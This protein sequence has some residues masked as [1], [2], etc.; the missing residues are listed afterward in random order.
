MGGRL[1]VFWAHW[2]KIDPG[3]WVLDVVKRGYEIEFSS[4]PPQYGLFATTPVPEIP[5]KRAA[6]E[7]EI[8]SLLKKGAITRVTTANADGPLFR[9]SFFLTPKK[10]GTWR[11]ILNLRPLNRRFIRPERFRMETLTSILHLLRPGMWASSVDLKDA[12]LHIPIRLEDQRF[13][14]FRYK[15]IDYRFTAL[16]FGLSTAPRVFTRVT[17]AVLAH[18]RRN[19]VMVFA[20][21]D[22]WLVLGNS[23]QG[24]LAST[25]A[26]V[27][28]LTKLGWL[29]NVEKSN[30]VPTQSIIYLGARLDLASG[31]VYPTAE[32]T[33]SLV[34]T[35]RKIL[36]NRNTPALTWQRLLGKMASFTDLLDLCRLRMRPLQRHLLKHYAPDRSSAAT[37]IPLPTGLRPF[38]TWWAESDR[39]AAGR[40]FRNPAPTTSITTD[41]SLS[42]WGAVWGTHTVAGEWAEPERGL[43]IN[44]LETE[45]VLRAVRHWATHLTGHTV[46]VRS[47]NTT[48]VAY[49]NRQG[50]TRSLALLR[51]TWDLLVLCDSLRIG[52]RASHLA[53][54][55]NIL[56]DALSRGYLDNGEWELSRTWSDHIFHLFGRPSVDMFATAKNAKL[57]T[58][59]SRYHDPQAWKTDALVVSWA[60]LSMYAFPPLG[61]LRRILTML[62]DVEADMLLIAPCWPNQAWFPLIIEMLVDLPYKFP[63]AAKLLSQ[64]SGHITHPDITSLHLAAWKLSGSRSRQRGFH[65]RLRTL[66]W[67]PAGS[68][69]LKHTILDCTDTMFGPG[70]T[71]LIP[72]RPQ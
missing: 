42:G 35:A 33:A 48:T 39:I 43:H 25:N 55:D 15:A 45:A 40:P 59:C 51:R 6:L 46:T 30:L 71:L 64:R 1:R 58:F 34:A 60:G 49:I 56:A 36:G 4:T 16:P 13:L 20:Y 9:S 68:P 67:M 69:R 14:A 17:R 31:M 27:S 10:N 57:P 53:G 32:R 12:Y 62:R 66:Q 8:N 19:G 63:P 52:L 18:L 72:W 26:T 54:K 22:D 47:D 5:E 23:Q 38:L 70:T 50:G 24:A 7:D 41:A 44:I 29:I 11:P 21:L 61:L 65:R 37:P 2:E 3:A 28:L